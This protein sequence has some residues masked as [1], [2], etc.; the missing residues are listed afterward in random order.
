M[1]EVAN[2]AP[3]AFLKAEPEAGMCPVDIF[4]CTDYVS[5]SIVFDSEA[6]RADSNWVPLS[7]MTEAS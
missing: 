1:V 7:V 4:E 5:T 2:V 3:Q 6:K